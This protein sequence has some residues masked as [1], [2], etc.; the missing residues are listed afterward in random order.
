MCQG[1]CRKDFEFRARGKCSSS[2]VGNYKRKNSKMLKLASFLGP[3]R[4][5]DIA[6]SWSLECFFLFYPWILLFLLGRR[7]SKMCFLPFSQILH[8]LCRI[9]VFFILILESYFFPSSKAFF[10]LLKSFIFKNSHLRCR[11]RLAAGTADS[12][13]QLNN[14]IFV[15][16]PRVTNIYPQ[17][18]VC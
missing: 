15:T 4:C 5:R 1:T 2:E 11:V 7:A 9:H 6:V 12:C 3:W 18:A 13:L 10:F 16:Q 14:K 17:S 8:F